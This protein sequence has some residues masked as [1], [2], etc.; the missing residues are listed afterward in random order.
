MAPDPTVLFANVVGR[1]VPQSR[2]DQVRSD[3]AGLR[4]LHLHAARKRLQ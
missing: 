2:L 3:S 4:A 1:G